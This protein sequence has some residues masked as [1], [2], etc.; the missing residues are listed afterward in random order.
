L[1][2]NI[3]SVTSLNLVPLITMTTENTETELRRKMAVIG[4]RYLARTHTEIGELRTLIAQLASG[5]KATLKEIE[6]LAHRIRGSGA[7]FGFTELSEAAEGIEML[8]VDCAF[9]D[10]LDL[11]QLSAHLTDYLA[12]LTQAVARALQAATP[13]V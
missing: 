9:E 3:A 8:A 11:G 5:G 13:V 6:M 12:A 7:I 1:G 2:V 4:A 10:D